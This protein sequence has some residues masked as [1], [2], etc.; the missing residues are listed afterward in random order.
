VQNGEQVGF[1]DDIWLGD[2]P[3][4]EAYPNLYRIPRR[5]DDTVVNVLRTVLLNVLFRRGLV[6]ENLSLCS[7]FYYG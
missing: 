6:R 3:F 4:R 2:K 1:W 5:K 7:H